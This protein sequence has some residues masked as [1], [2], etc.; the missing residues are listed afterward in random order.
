[1]ALL[2]NLVDALASRAGWKRPRQDEDGAYRFRLENGLDF[3]VFS[4]D[5]R[6]AV[7]RAEFADVPASGPDREEML[8]AAAGRQA[9]V[10]RIRASVAAL[11]RPGQS[12]LKSASGSGDRLVLYRMAELAAGQEAF[13]AAVRD[14]LNDLAWWKAASGGDG[15]LRRGRFSACR[16]CLGASIEEASFSLLSFSFCLLPGLRGGRP[17]RVLHSVPAALFPL[18]GK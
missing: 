14:F 8:R 9:G 7:L 17:L 15:Q 16:A 2:N 12:L 10:C 11:E 5:G 6:A 4:P 1:M 3:A 13:D 18:C